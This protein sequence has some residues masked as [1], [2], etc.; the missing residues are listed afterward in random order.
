MAA[1]SKGEDPKERVNR[2][3]IEFLNELRVALP[4]VQVLFAF[5]LTVPFSQRFGDVDSGLRRVYFVAVLCAALAS[6][7]FIAPAAHHRLRFRTGNKEQML[8]VG[9]VLATIG[10]V[11]LAAGMGASLYLIASFLYGG[12]WAAL[13]VAVVS[14]LTVLL[15]FA[16]PFLFKANTER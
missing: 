15:W 11:F 3:F 2:E 16:V 13:T 4:G 12:G 5:L 7:L 10:T 1:D 6:A 14:G 8:K 9:T